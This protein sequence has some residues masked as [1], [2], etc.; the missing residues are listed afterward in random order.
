VLDQPVDTCFVGTTVDV[1]CVQTTAMAK[2]TDHGDE[3]ST[4][5]VLAA[6]PDLAVDPAHCS[7]TIYLGR[8]FV[9]RV[10]IATLT[11][12]WPASG[13]PRFPWRLSPDADVQARI[14]AGY[15][16]IH[17]DGAAVGHPPLDAFA[18]VDWLYDQQLN[19]GK[20]RA[21]NIAAPIYVATSARAP[22]PA[23]GGGSEPVPAAGEAA[24]SPPSAM[25][26]VRP[27]VVADNSASKAD[28][29][30]RNGWLDP[31]SSHGLFIT[32][33]AESAFGV[34]STTLLD[35]SDDRGML[36]EGWVTRTML[37]YPWVANTVVNASWGSYS[38]ISHNRPVHPLMFSDLVQFLAGK[39]V[40]LVA[41]AGNNATSQPFYPAA[42]GVLPT[43][44]YADGPSQCRGVW[45]QGTKTCT[46][47]LSPSVTSVGSVASLAKGMVS[48]V[49]P[50][51]WER[52]AFSNWGLWVEQWAVGEDVVASYVGG[53]YRYCVVNPGI[54]C[55]VDGVITP[56][57]DA[58]T[59][60]LGP[61]VKWSGT[62]FAAPQ[63]AIQLASTPPGP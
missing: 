30:D 28:A 3:D 19:F 44:V 60:H 20:G 43:P 51:P 10:S 14:P 6:N 62:S 42:F 34:G 49:T 37:S 38:C 12:P 47:N 9:S 54:G 39:D 16:A 8:T 31:S 18:L 55:T 35:V 41:A 50:K 29:M 13:T 7:A 59:A 2:D 32:S 46:L 53:A 33:M 48:T 23:Y 58:P 22:Q 45:D 40:H 57:V 61:R 5:A 52:S 15:F 4:A 27:L 63:A 1:D 56:E 21:I 36:Q 11:A 26:R 17:I 25:T 24:W